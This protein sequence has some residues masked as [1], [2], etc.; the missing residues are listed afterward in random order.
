MSPKLTTDDESMW[1][2]S[3]TR[4]S[5]FGKWLIYIV[6]ACLLLAAAVYLFETHR[7]LKNL[8]ENYIK[9]N[10]SSLSPATNTDDN[11]LTTGIAAYNKKEYSKA[12]QIFES[13]EEADPS[14]GETKKY[15][16]LSYLQM[17]SYDTA[18]LQ[19]RDLSTKNSIT[20]NPGDFLQALTL[21]ERNNKGDKESAEQLLQK[22]VDEKKEDNQE[23][24]ELLKKF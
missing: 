7:S 14:N 18:L 19:F 8:A 12:V 2:I 1:L 20:N 24:K 17:K 13:T 15:L 16:G 6:A 23:A 4:K 11:N 21:L 22:V 3:F 5:T 10:Y 9:T